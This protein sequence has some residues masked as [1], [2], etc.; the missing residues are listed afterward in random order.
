MS[1]S[2]VLLVHSAAEIAQS[3]VAMGDER[4][5]ASR[6]SQRQYLA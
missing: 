2:L 3:P 4:P 6:L 1:I 5:H